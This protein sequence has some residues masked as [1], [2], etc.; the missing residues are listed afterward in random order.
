MVDIELLKSRIPY[1]MKLPWTIEIKPNRQGIYTAKVVELPECSV[2]ADTVYE[3]R[4]MLNECLE[5]WFEQA[6]N[7]GVKIPLPLVFVEKEIRK[8]LINYKLL[9]CEIVIVVLGL[10][11]II[12]LLRRY[13]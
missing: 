12:E 11:G 2:E 3:A 7:D 5:L 9:G 4:E 13:L 8:E 1:L 10:V 6:I